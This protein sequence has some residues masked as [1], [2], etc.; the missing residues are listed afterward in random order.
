V[1]GFSQLLRG[2]QYTSSLSF[3]DV[4]RQAEGSL[5]ED[6]YGYRAEFV[7]LVRKAERARRM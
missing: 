2:G 3:E 4:I 1:A 5:G 6:P 7:E